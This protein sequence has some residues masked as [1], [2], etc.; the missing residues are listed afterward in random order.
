MRSSIY[1]L[2]SCKKSLTPL[3]KKLVYNSLVMSHL[4]YGITIWGPGLSKKHI[5]I[6][7]VQQNK[8]INSLYNYY[9]NKTLT[10]KY[11]YLEIMKIKELIDYNILLWMHKFTHNQLPLSL[12]STFNLSTD[13]HT[14]NLRKHNT[15]IHNMAREK[16]YNQSILIYGP[17]LWNTLTFDQKDLEDKIVKK[18]FK[19]LMFNRYV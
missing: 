18:E 14:Y 13:R 6:L 19:E 3:A 2:H 12:M 17:Q 10:E 5:N 16:H 15:L 4:I 1:A 11:H 8:C 7:Q 9:D